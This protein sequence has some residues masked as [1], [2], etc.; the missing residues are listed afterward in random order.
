[1]QHVDVAIV[2]GGILGLATGYHLTHRAPELRVSVFEK[3]E[4]LARHQSGRNSGVIHSGIYYEP[5]SL[6]A[7][8]CRAGKQALEVFCEVEE[9]PFEQCGKV[10]VATEEAERP[11]LKRIYERG[12]ANGVDCT[13]IGPQR[14]QEIEPHASGVQAIHVPE[15][16]VVD[17]RQVALR[18]AERIREKDGRIHTGAEVQRLQSQS[19]SVVVSTPE[20][21]VEAQYVINCAGLY[22]DRVATMSGEA[23]EVQIVPFRGEYYE[24]TPEAHSLCNGLIYPVPNPDFPFLGVHF[25]RTIDGNVECGPNAVLSF[26]REGYRKTD[27]NWSELAETLSYSGFQTLAGR[28]WRTGLGEVWR[29]LSKSAFVRALQTL[30]PEIKEEHLT[31]APAGVRAQ[32]VTPDGQLLDDFLIQEAGRVV[33]VCNAPSPGAT[34]C[35]S[36]ASTIAERLGE[37]DDV[38]RS[39]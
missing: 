9:I 38:V 5:G 26:A 34:S 31:A 12:Q 8:N 16:G 3:E 14:L 23:P 25:T 29:S 10:I 20:T 21:E 37:L 27:V 22:S 17:Y 19:D 13:L 1:M 36:I 2:G 24:L 11:A 4:E 30:V 35:L 32:A 6:K 15:T 28:Y 33:N 7:E 18:F 39:Q